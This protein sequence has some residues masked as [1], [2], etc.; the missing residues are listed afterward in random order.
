[1]FLNAGKNRIEIGKTIKQNLMICICPKRLINL[2]KKGVIITVANPTMDA[3]KPITTDVTP[4]VLRVKELKG[5]LIPTITPTS[6]IAVI[7][8]ASDLRLFCLL[9]W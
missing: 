6:A 4:H 1:M 9:I 3:E 7:T 8:L 2:E 5:R